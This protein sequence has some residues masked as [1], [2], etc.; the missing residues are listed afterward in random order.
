MQQLYTS[1]AARRAL[2]EQ[3]AARDNEGLEDETGGGPLAADDYAL[4]AADDTD[5]APKSPTSLQVSERS[6]QEFTREDTEEAKVQKPKKLWTHESAI[7]RTV[8][9]EGW[10]VVAQQPF[11]PRHFTEQQ[12]ANWA[13][14]NTGQLLGF[15]SQKCGQPRQASQDE[16]AVM[17]EA[18]Y[19]IY[20]VVDGHGPSGE[21]VAQ[22]TRRF[23][24]S[25]LLG[26]VRRRDG[27]VLSNGELSSIFADLHR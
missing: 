1:K 14:V 24:V 9:R 20:L 13:P 7:V 16:Y 27:R 19:Q 2:A 18:G 17:H 26:L 3:D 21:V 10:N 23:L 15:A 11:Q 4:L 12:L 25:A 8:S 22:F 5:Q 6:T